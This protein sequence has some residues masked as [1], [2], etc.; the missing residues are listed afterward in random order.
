MGLFSLRT[1]T[2][3]VGR[4]TSNLEKSAG[5]EFWDFDVAA[6]EHC[7]DNPRLAGF[8]F[9]MCFLGLRHP[10]LPQTPTTRNL[11]GF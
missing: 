9:G 3:G 6:A 7:S 1:Y 4:T 10:T 2:K 5:L 11:P 8:V